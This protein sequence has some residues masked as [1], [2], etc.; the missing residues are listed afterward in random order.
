M[1]QCNIS[2]SESLVPRSGHRDSSHSFGQMDGYNL[3]D[4]KWH[5]PLHPKYT[6]ENDIENFHS[7][8][9]MFWK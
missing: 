6:Y 7:I 9:R 3:N 5:E 4:T 8:P 1:L 2:K